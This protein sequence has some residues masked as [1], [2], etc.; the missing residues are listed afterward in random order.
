[1]DAIPG[2]QL[3]Q[4]TALS[5]TRTVGRSFS[6]T[7]QTIHTRDRSEIVNRFGELSSDFTP[8]AVV[9]FCSVMTPAAGATTSTTAVGERF[10]SMP[11]TF[12]RSAAQGRTASRQ[13]RARRQR[14]PALDRDRGAAAR[15]ALHRC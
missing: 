3:H 11:R 2:R 15:P 7:S 10:E 1:I 13:G 5:L 8:A 4:P 6:Y 14:A 9:T 12:R